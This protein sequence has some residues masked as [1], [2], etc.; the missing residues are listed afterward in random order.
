[1]V[2]E[3]HLIMQLGNNFK[4]L[5][6]LCLQNSKAKYFTYPQNQK[7]FE[8]GYEVLETFLSIYTKTSIIHHEYTDRLAS[9]RIVSHES[10]GIEYK[11][12]ATQ[13]K[14][15]SR[16][17]NIAFFH[18]GRKTKPFTMESGGNSILAERSGAGGMEMLGDPSSTQKKIKRLVK[19]NCQLHFHRSLLIFSQHGFEPK[20]K[21]ELEEHSAFFG[22]KRLLSQT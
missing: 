11:T 10:A 9:W 22:D 3:N 13:V 21:S 1:M 16:T 18:A 4:T 20:R 14:P 17:K 19:L 15:S 2:C 12:M 7:P 6:Q 5:P 8:D